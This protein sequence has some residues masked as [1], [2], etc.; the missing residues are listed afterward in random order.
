MSETQGVPNSVFIECSRSQSEEAHALGLEF[1][2]NSV[3]TTQLKSGVQIN[4][5]DRISVANASVSAVGNQSGTLEF[6][7]NLTGK[8]GSKLFDN[9]A[10]IE[11]QE[12]KAADGSYYDFFPV[13]RTRGDVA[14]YDIALLQRI[15]PEASISW[16]NTQSYTGGVGPDYLNAPGSQSYY[17]HGRMI[18][19]PT[20]RHTG[21]KYTRMTFDINTTPAAGTNLAKIQP[22][23][24][25][26]PADP[27]NIANHPQGSTNYSTSIY[28][29]LQG[30]ANA[31]C[32]GY[33]C[34]VNP[35]IYKR[36][37]D[38]EIPSGFQN[39]TQI[40]KNITQ[41]LQRVIDIQ[42]IRVNTKLEALKYVPG[43]DPN[44]DNPNMTEPKQ[45]NPYT[46]SAV[47][48]YSEPSEILYQ[49]TQGEVISTIITTNSFQPRDAVP[50][51]RVNNGKLSTQGGI[52]PAQP[53]GYIFRADS[54]SR[55]GIGCPGVQP[56]PSVWVLSENTNAVI[57]EFQ[58]GP[59]ISIGPKAA[60]GAEPDQNMGN[61][62]QRYAQPEGQTGGQTGSIDTS[63][64]SYYSTYGLAGQNQFGGLNMPQDP[65]NGKTTNPGD[66]TSVADLGMESY[67]LWFNGGGVARCG[68]SSDQSTYSQLA[69]TGEYTE[70]DSSSALDL[71][72]Y[73]RDCYS[74]NPDFLLATIDWWNEFHTQ[75]IRSF[76][77][78]DTTQYHPTIL[79]CY[80]TD[81]NDQQDYPN[82]L[83]PPPMTTLSQQ[84]IGYDRSLL[85]TY[86]GG[87]SDA[88]VIWD[89]DMET[90]KNMEDN[91]GEKF[92]KVLEAQTFSSFPQHDGSILYEKKLRVNHNENKKRFIEQ[93]EPPKGNATSTE[94][95]NGDA[96]YPTRKLIHI[97]C[98]D[99][100]YIGGKIVMGQGNFP[101]I[102]NSVPA[103]HWTMTLPG[104]K[105]VNVANRYC[106][107]RQGTGGGTTGTFTTTS[108]N[109]KG[110][111]IRISTEE[112]G[113]IIVAGK[114][115]IGGGITI[116]QC[117]EEYVSGDSIT[118]N[119]ADVILAFGGTPTIT[120]GGDP[121]I[122]FTFTGTNPED[123]VIYNAA[124]Q[125]N[126]IAFAENDYDRATGLVLG[127]PVY[128]NHNHK[129]NK[130][131]EGITRQTTRTEEINA[132]PVYGCVYGVL[133][134]TL[135]YAT[136]PKETDGTIALNNFKV[137]FKIKRGDCVLGNY[138]EKK[139]NASSSRDRQFGNQFISEI[140]GKYVSGRHPNL[141]DIGMGYNMGFSPTWTAPGNDSLS[142]N[143]GFP[144]LDGLADIPGI[145]Q[146]NETLFIGDGTSQA[147]VQD[148]K[149][150]LEVSKTSELSD[151]QRNQLAQWVSPWNAISKSLDK[152][153]IG[154]A[155]PK[156]IYDEDS[157]KF[158]FQD[159]HTPRMIH[160]SF[161]VGDTLTESV[162]NEKGEVVQK[163]GLSATLP[164]FTEDDNEIYRWRFPLTYSTGFTTD[165]NPEAGQPI[166]TFGP[167]I[168]QENNA[169]L[170]F[171]RNPCAGYNSEKGFL[172]DNL[173]G[174]FI[175]NFN[176]TTGGRSQW[177]GSLWDK[178]GFSYDNTHL[179]SG[180]RNT[181]NKNY[182]ETSPKLLLTSNPVTTG[183]DIQGQT[184]L[185][186][187]TGRFNQP[188]Y[189]LGMN[190]NISTIV[191]GSL[192]PDIFK[193]E[194]VMG[195]PQFSASSTNF[196]AFNLP[197]KTSFANY[198]ITSDICRGQTNYIGGH[199]SGERLD[200]IATI[201]KY[202][203]G[204]DFFYGTDSSLG[205][206]ATKNYSLNSIRIEIRN[207]DGSLARNLSPN[208]SILFK[209]DRGN[210]LLPTIDLS[211][212][213]TPEPD[214]QPNNI[215]I[216]INDMIQ[217]FQ[218]NQEIKDLTGEARFRQLREDEDP[219]LEQFQRELDEFDVDIPDPELGQHPFTGESGGEFRQTIRRVQEAREFRERFRRLEEEGEMTEID[220]NTFIGRAVLR[221]Q[222]ETGLPLNQAVTQILN[223]FEEQGVPRGRVI[224]GEPTEERVLTQLHD[225]E[226][227][228]QFMRRQQELRQIEE[229]HTLEQT[230][231]GGSMVTA[232]SQ[233]EGTKTEGTMVT[234]GSGTGTRVTKESDPVTTPSDP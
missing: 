207:T 3:Y 70:T 41:Q 42:Q 199:S 7:G 11:L 117:G 194:M 64:P 123:Y 35:S 189:T 219:D 102:P 112:F 166:Y 97:E 212:V 118:I 184:A 61:R 120:D 27:T 132:N 47:T 228:R 46:T 209:I 214:I 108:T 125:L 74:L 177:I 31:G 202:Y 21:H 140:R 15:I 197:T 73:L 171:D 4:R 116:Y 162:T 77:F 174:I 44:L 71:Y 60:N 203:S 100:F 39:P 160:N 58:I 24:I 33:L 111:S 153:M 59:V 142:L 76:N 127:Q 173:T 213:E 146:D 157:G 138:F 49:D 178:L 75:N 176:T 32:G 191:G 43:N 163:A 113:A 150:P 165:D 85:N 124:T 38:I 53:T 107:M 139:Y 109:G 26:R 201:Q 222:E 200:T 52:N 104:T 137:A 136:V 170:M 159:L 234:A 92:L 122:T 5:G 204:N 80:T 79:G 22:Y 180:G 154:A 181:R 211:N 90:F 40:A 19:P 115:P 78:A 225:P 98:R 186:L 8:T 233:L 198:T 149:F 14:N 93:T 169:G 134:P 145:T 224:L 103:A 20:A 9:K 28:D 196:S 105:Y 126:S 129:D 66:L 18:A 34:F 167:I 217:N 99:P 89:L 56:H 190:R 12:Y 2:L 69:F 87:G 30:T 68:N 94:I 164:T 216:Q 185:Q 36:T 133:D 51:E 114:N 95:E 82:I 121:N 147:G 144:L 183:A 218:V 96:N 192:P 106:V 72:K 220:P 57:R 172:F 101:Q 13:T 16:Y 141:V 156:I 205:F 148:L 88:M 193:D 6:Q 152:V 54:N 187:A 50:M 130:F 161:M 25:S 221:L 29:A 168:Y 230:K 17:F 45:E 10:T 226:E 227:Q 37:L 67:E 188:L 65:L 210:P 23:T 128:Y 155:Q 62:P 55:G 131:I 135:D 223:E 84:E 232:E 86:F 110:L 81:S 119:I 208:S 83:D 1:G 215:D 63:E 158:I 179:T 229:P 91:G 182:F 231:S 143:N 206:T 195:S 175:S 48:G 151:A